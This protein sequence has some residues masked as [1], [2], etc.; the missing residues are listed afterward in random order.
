MEQYTNETVTQLLYD[1]TPGTDLSGEFS[2]PDYLPDVRRVLYVTAEPHTTGRY[3]NGERLELEGTT[4]ITLLYLSDENTLHSFIGS[5]PFT[6]NIPIPHLDENTVVTARVTADN[7]A[8][9]LSGPR[10]CTLRCRVRFAVRA[11]TE[12]SVVPDTAALPPAETLCTKTVTQPAV[13]V[14]SVSRDDLRYAE[15]IAAGGIIYEVLSSSVTPVVAECRA[16]RDTVTV[17]GDYFIRALCAFS[18]DTDTSHSYRVLERRIPFSEELPL[19]APLPNDDHVLLIPDLAVT[20]CT[21]TVTEEGRNLGIDFS[22]ECAVL[23]TCDAP[24][25]VI[26]DAFLPTEDV[27]ITFDDVSSYLPLCV[28]NGTYTATGTLKYDTSD[29][30]REVIDCR[31]LPRIDRI[32]T[33]NGFTVITG[34][35]QTTALARCENGSFLPISGNIPLHWETDNAPCSRIPATEQLLACEMPVTAVQ[36]KLDPDGTIAVEVTLRPELSAAKRL[37]IPLPRAISVPA[38]AKPFPPSPFSA[39]LFY[40][41]P[42]ES[43]WDIARRYRMPPA[44]ICLANDLPTDTEAVPDGVTVLLIPTSALFARPV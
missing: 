22:V 12:I 26:T 6:E 16:G 40:P 17:K 15:D 28:F 33:E 5:V 8:C 36:T 23:C 9:R 41:M 11:L 13:C 38:D 30:V 42:G 32:T 19:S 39:V 21:P 7:G 20:V 43:L 29:G 3:M 10:K 24:V 35:L 4:E 44:D 2:L 14:R 31:V 34:E 18:D 1:A 25:S 27:R 37:T